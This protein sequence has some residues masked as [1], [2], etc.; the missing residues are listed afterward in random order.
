MEI[1]H[2]GYL[3]KN[4]EKAKELF[5]KFGYILEKDVVYDEIRDI[6]ICFLCNEGYRIELV[7]PKS[8]DSVVADTIKK[9]GESPYHICYY[10]SDIESTVKNMR[11]QGFIP[12]S[13]IQPA[14]A[15]DGKRVCFMY[16]RNMGLIEFVEK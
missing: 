4:I 12:T 6:N 1:H 14:P 9:M 5:L 7:S 3:V 16:K 8:K 15:I 13:E 10:V 11:E 2:V